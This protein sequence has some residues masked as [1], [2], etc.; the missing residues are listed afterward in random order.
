MCMGPV[1][2]CGHELDH[3]LLPSPMLQLQKLSPS[4][5]TF[6]RTSEYHLLPMRK[7]MNPGPATSTLSNQL[8]SSFM[9]AISVSATLRGGMRISFALAI[10]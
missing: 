2:F 1:G 5:A 8:P 7:F 3:E 10:A 6:L 4:S 9:F